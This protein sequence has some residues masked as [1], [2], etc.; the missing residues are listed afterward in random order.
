MVTEV[1][2]IGH[3]VREFFH[4]AQLNGAGHRKLIHSMRKLFLESS[5][6]GVTGEEE[7]FLSIVH[8]LNIMLAVRKTEEVVSRGMRFLL[9]FVVW[10]AEKDEASVLGG[11]TAT[12]RLIENLMLYALEGIDVKERLVRVRLAQLMVACVS[13]VDELSDG[14]WKIF[15]T[16]MT[17][18][19]FDKEAAV[20]VQAVHAMSRLQ[21]LP[22]TE[23]GAILI[24]D[25]FLELLAHDPAADVR[26]TV[27]E[28]LN[29]TEAT[30]GRILLRCRDIDAGVRKSLFSRKMGEI[31]VRVLSI[32]QRDEL[33]RCGLRDRDAGVRKAVIE[34]VFTRWIA[35]ADNNLVQLLLSLDVIQHT[36]VAEAA[37]Q[38][39]YEGNPDMF[40]SGFPTDSFRHL[41]PETAIAL[42]VY[43]EQVGAERAAELIPE[44]SE[45]ASHIQ[46]IYK[47]AF[48]G[49][50]IMGEGDQRADAEFVMVQILKASRL[51]DAAD[52]MGRRVMQSVVVDLLANLELG[53]VLFDAALT[54]LSHL[55]PSSA[56]FIGTVG[57]L[58][59]DLHDLYDAPSGGAAPDEDG[60]L[61][62]SLESL[63]IAPEPVVLGEDIR[64]LSQ[65]RCLQI[66]AQSFKCLPPF[67]SGPSHPMFLGLLN[68]AVIP[69]VNSPY[70]AVQCKGL[71][72]LGLA[73]VLREELA[74]EYLQL[75]VEFYRLGGDET[76]LMALR[77]I[78]DLL[79][80]HGPMKDMGAVVFDGIADV[81]CP[82]SSEDRERAKEVQAVAAEGYAKLLLHRRVDTEGPLLGLLTLYYDPS[83]ADNPRLR[84]I[85]SYFLQAFALSSAEHQM[86]LA[87]TVLP[88]LDSM[89]HTGADANLTAI[90]L[91]LLELTDPAKLIVGAS[92]PSDNSDANANAHTY[93]AEAF[94]WAALST[95]ASLPPASKLYTYLLCRLRIDASWG[96]LAI[97]RLLFVTGQLIRATEKTQQTSVKRLVALL[98]E[99]DDPT[100]VLEGEELRTL[101]DRLATVEMVVRQAPLVKTS[102][103][104]N[105]SSLATTNVMDE[106]SDIL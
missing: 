94:A 25:V 38:A 35:V 63:S 59:S 85:L 57:P 78:F 8:C 44:M 52:E 1:D 65:L 69:A 56:S 43:C 37:L 67:R 45:L 86:F 95:A 97:K 36:D 17:E 98:V 53:E 88:L 49:G 84:Q 89:M 87:Q 26:R 75:F 6:L 71:Y 64:I 39:F 21:Q 102:R 70:A 103:M 72:C 50:G 42:R 4:T 60:R 47:D 74:A 27:L 79:L 30:L 5:E 23:D 7:F 77:I 20:R 3:Q 31:D 48:L 96:P 91:Q 73:C 13:S 32:K 9:G 104:R 46:C 80:S 105:P 41:T 54:T 92:N 14:V 58:L 19:L 12:S 101:R 82:S 100:Q 62:H 83:T 55:N 15:R 34:M 51:L 68:D 99:L 18:R 24:Q 33:L 106:I 93:L 10:S 40:A 61:Q 90:G 28:A 29:V 81:L 76:R 16:K 66:I 22:L 2:N 11:P